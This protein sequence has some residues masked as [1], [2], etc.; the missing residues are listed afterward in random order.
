M[1][2]SA[3]DVVGYVRRVISY[4]DPPL[5]AE[6]VVLRR[7]D[8]RDLSFV[9]KASADAEL[10][11][12]TTL[13]DPF[14]EDAGLAFIERQWNRVERGEGLSL[15]IEERG[16]GVA[17]GC[18]TLML[19]RVEVADLGYWL[20]R[21]ARGRGIGK[22]TVELVV[23]W[24]LQELSVEAIEAFVHSENHPSRSILD[25]CGFSLIGSRRHT[26]GRI[27]EVLLVYRRER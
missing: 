7:W 21:D 8:R 27:D 16:A 23:P 12:G 19:R 2:P 9:R 17:V 20:V 24:G 26:V 10:L 13:P 5:V 22:A 18:T 1:H 4:P 25:A 14:T 11:A 15:A 3:A 6:N